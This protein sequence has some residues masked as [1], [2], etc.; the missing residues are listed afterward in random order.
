MDIQAALQC[1]IALDPQSAEYMHVLA[2]L[3]G[4]LTPGKMNANLANA[5]MRIA[6][7]SS[8]EG[9][10]LR[11]NNRS[12]KIQVFLKQRPATEAHGNQWHCSGTLMRASENTVEEVMNRL[13]ETDFGYKIFLKYEF[14]GCFIVAN[15]E[16][17]T[18]LS[19]IYLVQPMDLELGEKYGQW[20]DVEN[21]P[22]NMVPHHLKIIE[23]AVRCKF[24][25]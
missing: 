15:D 19:H 1:L 13:A 22:E 14:T 7:L 16:R 5:V 21:L 11:R 10:W 6:N 17:G 2:V 18:L 9:V 20:F 4:Q 24:P 25:F 23:I 12:K 3:L 8:F